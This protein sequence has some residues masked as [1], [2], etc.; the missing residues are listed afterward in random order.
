[1]PMGKFAH[2]CLK[3]DIKIYVAGGKNEAFEKSKTVHLYDIH[4][5]EWSQIESLPVENLIYSGMGWYS[6]WM[7]I[8][9]GVTEGMS[10]SMN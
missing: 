4:K 6:G 2:A 7:T 10:L 1:M 9:G 3:N 5:N 8:F